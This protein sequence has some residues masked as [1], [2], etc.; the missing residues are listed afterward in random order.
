MQARLLPAL[1]VLASPLCVIAEDVEVSDLR[2]SAGVL[3]NHFVGGST[4]T[5]TDSGGA[6]VSTT[7]GSSDGRDSDRNHRAAIGLMCGH[8][9]A[10]GG[11]LI[12]AD[13]AVNHA[14]FT[15]GDVDA[16]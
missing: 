2:L 14:V 9:Q 6:V 12:G 3:S 15:T 1:L 4:T 10:G 16:H 7:N 8:L 11:F 5:V 13:F